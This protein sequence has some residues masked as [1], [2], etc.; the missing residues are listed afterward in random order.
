M[1][2]AKGKLARQK[3]QGG[4]GRPPDNLGTINPDAAAAAVRSGSIR[5]PGGPA[6]VE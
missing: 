1:P 2:A 3:P 5:V 4:P 6:W